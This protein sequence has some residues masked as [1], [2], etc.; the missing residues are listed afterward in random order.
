MTG[1]V[2]W[3]RRPL[4]VG[5]FRAHLESISARTSCCTFAVIT[6]GQQLRVG[7]P[8][9]LSPMGLARRVDRRREQRS[10]FLEVQP[11]LAVGE[12]TLVL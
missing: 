8:T 4:G 10:D 7:V 6:H 1:S 2:T 5:V 3:D 9:S 11:V 12:V